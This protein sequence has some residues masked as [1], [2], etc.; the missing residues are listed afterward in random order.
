MFVPP[1]GVRPGSLP[2][3]LLMGLVLVIAAPGCGE[4]GRNGVEEETPAAQQTPAQEAASEDPEEVEVDIQ[5]EYMEDVDQVAQDPRVQQAFQI[6]EDLEPWTME[7]L[8][9]IT[10]IPAPPFM[11]DERAEAFLAMLEEIGVDEAYRDDEGNVIAVRRG[12]VGDRLLVASGHLDTVF[13]EGTDVTVQFRG[14]TLYAPGVGDDSRG[15]AVLLTVLRAMN[16]S[17]IRT[18]G[19]I[20]FVGTVGEEGL[21]DL[22]GVK[23]LF[24]DGGPEIDAFISVDGGGDARVVNQALGSRRYR[25]TFQGPGGHSWGAFGL[26]NPAHALGRAIELFDEAAADFVREG[27]RTSYNVGRIGGGTS[28]NS[29]PFEAWMEVDMRSIDQDRLQGIDALF[30]ETMERALEEQNQRVLD[31]P[32]LEVEVDQVGDRP[33]GEIDPSTPFVQRTLATVAHFGFEP[34]LGRASTDSNVPISMGIPSVTIGRGG[35]GDG[36][37]SLDEWWLNEDGHIAIQR[38]LLLL[39]AEAGLARD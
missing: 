21:G 12:T 17:E 5:D 22:R 19:D 32:E 37:H 2:L 13:P 1:A 38:T 9:T 3:A 15:L 8:I 28:V 14:D 24:R 31:G 36:A 16:E 34:Q 23:H 18:E 7:N 6:I 39:T 35:A 20:W 11:E 26:G 33:S 25:V 4:E 27:P 29:I 30:L 10:E